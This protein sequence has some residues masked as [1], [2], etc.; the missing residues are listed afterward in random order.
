MVDIIAPTVQSRVLI[1]INFIL[2]NI[3]SYLKN[4]LSAKN[5][6]KGG[7]SSS[8][9]TFKHKSMILVGKII[10]IASNWRVVFIF[11]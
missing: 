5:K 3:I 7:G 8:S 1:Q 11:Q 4:E 10:E 9:F 6:T 2:K